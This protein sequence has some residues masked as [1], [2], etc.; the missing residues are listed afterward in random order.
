MPPAGEGMTGS[1]TLG[2]PTAGHT[3][4]DELNAPTLHTPRGVTSSLLRL[5][6]RLPNGA[7][8][9]ALRPLRGRA[10]REP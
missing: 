6:H 7:G 8:L 10:P 2:L 1:L 3:G 4:T 5:P 9:K